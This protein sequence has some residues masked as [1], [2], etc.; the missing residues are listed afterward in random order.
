M[1]QAHDFVNQALQQG[2]NLWSGVPC[3]Y[4]KAFIN[5]VIDDPKVRY[6]PASN[7]G[8]A[9]AIAGGNQHR[10]ETPFV[11]ITGAR[12]KAQAAVQ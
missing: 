10:T 2:F 4:L 1:I 6:I 9:V 11:A 8:D 12:S 3:S 7:E 5:Y